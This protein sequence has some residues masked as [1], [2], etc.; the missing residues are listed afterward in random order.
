MLEDALGPSTSTARMRTRTYSARGP[1]VLE[2][3]KTVSML[4]D[5][6]ALGL[7][8][9]DPLKLKTKLNFLMSP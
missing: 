9:F 4:D 8:E 6:E 1:T 7:V 2:R 3:K 5:A